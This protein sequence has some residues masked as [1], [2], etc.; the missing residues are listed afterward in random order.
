MDRYDEASLL[1]GLVMWK[2][3]LLGV[4][5][6]AGCSFE[7][8]GGVLCDTE[9]ERDGARVCREGV[10]TT[11]PSPDPDVGDASN[12]TMVDMEHDL[13]DALADAEVDA[14]DAEADVE[15]DIDADV[16]M[17]CIPMSEAELCQTENLECGAAVRINNC[18]ETVEIECGNCASP[19]IC[20]AGGVA[21]ICGCEGSSDAALCAA[22]GLE[23]GDAQ[24]FDAACGVSRTVNC[25][26][27]NAPETCAGQGQANICGCEESP[28]AFCARLQGECGPVTAVDL[29]GTMRTYDCGGC[30]APEVCGA[31][32]ANQCGCSQQDICAAANATCGILPVTGCSNLVVAQCGTCDNGSCTNNA[33]FCSNGFQPAPGGCADVDE[34]ALGTNNCDG[35]AQCINNSGGFTCTCNPGYAGDGI[36]CERVF[37]V[38]V[39]QTGNTGTG[40]D[41]T[42]SS[43]TPNS[44]NDL[45][46]AVISIDTILRQV[47]T[48]Q[49]LGLSWQR[50]LTKTNGASNERL[51]VWTAR[52]N[53][54]GG[55]VE[56]SLSGDPFGLAVSILHV[57]NAGNIAKSA[58]DGSG[59]ISPANSFSYAFT[60]V[61]TDALLIA[62]N[63]SRGAQQTAGAGWTEIR[64][65]GTQS[66]QHMVMTRENLGG[67]QV[68]VAA[69]FSATRHWAS[70]VME[71]SSP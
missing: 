25:G 46:I 2:G 37:P 31:E 57:A 49:G 17:D 28:A 43:V 50:L 27:C 69:T 66:T 44:S 6:L 21:N 38:I 65:I 62:A 4:L 35:N 41:I 52:G 40:E 39:G 23:C 14:P 67:S 5:V 15:T 70:M 12:N 53:N 48:V 45:Y 26:G 47:D 30:I 42:V 29:C 64:E 51:E 18:G 13:P 68:N 9:G 54:T 8:L 59:A 7:P 11:S 33:C 55:D 1:T 22:A 34:C 19:L 58:T 60:P 3:L 56:V 36:N 71:I 32:V 61:T 24:V 20:G 10:W 16:D 63:T